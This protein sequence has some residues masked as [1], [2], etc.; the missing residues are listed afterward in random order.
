MV[1]KKLLWFSKVIGCLGKIN[2]VVS[3]IIVLSKFRF[4]LEF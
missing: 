2:F 3:K 1:L 4:L